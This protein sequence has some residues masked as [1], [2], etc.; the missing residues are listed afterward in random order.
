MAEQLGLRNVAKSYGAAVKTPVL[1]DISLSFE[2]GEF[3]AIIGQSGSGKTTLLNMIGVLD[4]PDSGETRFEGKN[5]YALS[6]DDLA[7]FR[8]VTLGFVFQFH[9]LLPEYS[10]LENVLLPYRIAHG[11]VTAAARKTAEELLDRVGVA[12]RKD[13]RSTNLSGGQQQRVAIAR[14]LMNRPQIILAD[15]PTGNLDSDSGENIRKLLREIN[16][17]FS[18]TFILV[19]HDRHVAAGCDRVIEVADGKIVEDVK[20]KGMSD[21][22]SW[23]RLAPCYCRMRQRQ[24]A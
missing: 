4:R 9:H 12:Q 10:A 7:R 19:T 21:A 22:E 17:E 2:K 15:E 16:R 20:V 6:D 5:L 8:N 18:T 1:R 23:D 14:A 11:R 24:E 13:N 3:A